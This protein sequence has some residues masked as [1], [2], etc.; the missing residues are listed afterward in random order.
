MLSLNLTSFNASIRTFP[1]WRLSSLLSTSVI[2]PEHNNLSKQEE[3]V[4]QNDDKYPKKEK[5]LQ[6]N[7]IQQTEVSR[8]SQSSNQLLNRTN[9]FISLDEKIIK[10][11][12][13]KDL[14][15]IMNDPNITIDQ[16]KQIISQISSLKPDVEKEKSTSSSVDTKKDF[17]KMDTISN[18]GFL[19]LSTPKIIQILKTLSYT[20]DRNVPLLKTLTYNIAMYSKKLNTRMCGDILYS[21]AVLN[22]PEEVLL[23]KIMSIL[24][25]ELLAN[26][27]GPVMGSIAMSLKLLKY[28]NYDVLD[29]IVLWANNNLEKLRFQDLTSI[30][31]CLAM[32]GYIPKLMNNLQDYINSLTPEITSNNQLWLDF[33][34]SLTLLNRASKEQISSV[35]YHKFI[36]R[37]INTRN[38]KNK[39]NALKILNINAAVRS[40]VK[41]YDGPCNKNRDLFSIVVEYKKQKLELIE[42][43]SETLNQIHPLCFKTNINTHMGFNIDV[44]SCVDSD[45]RLV[46]YVDSSPKNMRLVLM[47]HD[48]HDYSRGKEEI[49]GMPKFYNDLLIAQGYRVLNIS[50]QNFSANDIL[51]KRVKY[52]QDKI[53]SI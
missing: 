39:I 26:E 29:T 24:R 17:V 11:T 50:Y 13:T 18:I 44:E 45:N 10:T 28:K 20:N 32:F 4:I 15:G 52:L 51:A 43:L 27:N 5:V 37:I 19:P 34:W 49:L 21:L 30:M 42:A 9:S 16:V 6:R 40:I 2:N 3:S 33:V 46:K 1:Y 12:N 23:E 22:Y 41:D 14:I 35:L 7:T 8:I 38:N 36:E 48:Y 53:S 31:G 47:V 25:E